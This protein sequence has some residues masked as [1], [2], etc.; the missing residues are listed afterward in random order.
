MKLKSCVHIVATLHP[1]SA[2][3][4]RNARIC[5]LIFSRSR[6]FASL[7]AVARV[8][9]GDLRLSMVCDS[10]EST[11][12]THLKTNGSRANSLRTPSNTPEQQHEQKCDPKI[13]N[14]RKQKERMENYLSQ[15]LL[16]SAR[17]EPARKKIAFLLHKIFV[18]QCSKAMK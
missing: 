1:T 14:I 10:F 15:W 3:S 7:I 2:S 8:A 12:T 17:G 16:L 11:A 9:C 4:K 18:T 13:H 5:F 6:K